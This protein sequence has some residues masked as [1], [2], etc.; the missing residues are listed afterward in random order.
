MGDNQQ[1]NYGS[2]MTGGQTSKATVIPADRK[3]VST[4][5]GQKKEYQRLGEPMG[6]NQQPNYGSK[7]TGGQTSRA[8]VIPAERKHVSSLNH[9]RSEGRKSDCTKQKEYQRTGEPMGDN[10]QP[11]YGSH[12]TG[13]QTSRATVMPPVRKHVITMIGQKAGE[14]IAKSIKSKNKISPDN[15]DSR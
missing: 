10:Q 14:V 15:H 4:M 7:M 11:N 13:G 9:D 6:D 3:H 12:M 8:T 1:P 2:S 5:I